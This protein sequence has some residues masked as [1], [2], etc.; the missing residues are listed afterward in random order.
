MRELYTADM[1][2]WNIGGARAAPK[3]TV[4]AFVTATCVEVILRFVEAHENT[5]VYVAQLHSIYR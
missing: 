3:R 2:D 5:A 4:S 1:P